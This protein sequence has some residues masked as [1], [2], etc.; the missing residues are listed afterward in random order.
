M[1]A[2]S[3]QLT[4][5]DKG[6]IAI[7][8]RHRAQLATLCDSQLVITMGHET[9]LQLYPLPEFERIARDIDALENRDHA[10]LMKRAFV[11]RAVEVEIDKQGRIGLPPYLRK[12]AMLDS[13]V[14]L[15][16]QINRFEV[17]AD[18]RWHEM[19]GPGPNPT[20]AMLKDA[21]RSIKL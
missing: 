21:S 1:F 15:V 3:H 9:C 8:A 13:L 17:W 6:R 16:G 5:D 12:Q 20:S 19:F 11:G 18:E 10:E 2:G 14:M 4:V 7:P